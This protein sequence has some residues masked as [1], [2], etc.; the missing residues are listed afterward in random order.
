MEQ[1]YKA[2]F[3]TFFSTHPTGHI[4]HAISSRMDPNPS[5]E[6]NPDQSHLSDVSE[7][8]ELSLEDRLNRAVEVCENN[9]DKISIRKIARMYGVPNITLFHRIKGLPSKQIDCERRQ[10]LNYQKETALVDW[11]LCLQAW[12]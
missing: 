5:A 12:G 2:E 10:R 3:P 6:P 9:K 7:L 1:P 11:I 4:N 8:S